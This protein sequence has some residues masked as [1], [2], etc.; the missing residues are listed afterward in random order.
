MKIKVTTVY[1][2]AT[3]TTKRIVEH[4]ANQLSDEIT[5][6]DITNEDSLEEVNI[7]KEELLIVG[8]PVYAGRVPAM[9]VD[10]IRRFKGEG[11][12]T[13]AIAPYT[14]TVIMMTHYSNSRIFCP[15]TAFRLSLPVHSLPSIV[16]FHK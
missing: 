15:T 4:V 7:P 14:E 2:S 10:R 12:P 1:F 8:I 11:T 5:T 3:Y 9:A 13:V 16:Y 6:Y